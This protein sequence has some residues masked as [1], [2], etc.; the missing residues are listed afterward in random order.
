MPRQ[1]AVGAPCA[2]RLGGYDNADVH[3]TRQGVHLQVGTNG[4]LHLQAIRWRERASLHLRTP[5]A[6][7]HLGQ[8]ACARR[9]EH[10][11]AADDM[12]LVAKCSS[13]RGSELD[14]A[15]VLQAEE[16]A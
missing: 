3:R 6:A 15:H 11:Q 10:E 4:L 8:I 5:S 9:L 1:D 14:S 16:K 12:E 2:L 13:G 7:S